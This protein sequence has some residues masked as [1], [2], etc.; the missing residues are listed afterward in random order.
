VACKL[1]ALYINGRSK[2]EHFGCELVPKV[3][4]Q[5]HC[6]TNSRICLVKASFLTQISQPLQQVMILRT[7]PIL[8]GQGVLRRHLL[9]KAGGVLPPADP[10]FV[11]R[12]SPVWLRFMASLCSF[13]TLLCSTY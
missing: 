4:A 10:A 13:S 7:D 8:L 12:V 11:T 2:M 6:K 1:L 9:P 5:F 3:P